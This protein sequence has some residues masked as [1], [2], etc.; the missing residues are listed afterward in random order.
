MARMAVGLT[1]MIDNTGRLGPRMRAALA[2]RSPGGIGHARRDPPSPPRKLS[3]LQPLHQVARLREAGGPLLPPRIAAVELIKILPPPWPSAAM[4]PLRPCTSTRNGRRRRSPGLLCPRSAPPLSL[5]SG[6]RRHL[7]PRHL[8]RWLVLVER[9]LAA[10]RSSWHLPRPPA[11]PN[12]DSFDPRHSQSW[13]NFGFDVVPQK[14]G[15]SHREHRC[16]GERLTVATI[17]TAAHRLAASMRCTIPPQ[18][19]SAS[20]SR[21]HALPKSRMILSDISRA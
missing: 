5:L 6:H 21:I 18:D 4:S 9:R 17:R 20:P 11:L 15:N 3:N 12:L 14:A 10:G 8:T 13:H 7:L 1:A 2:R 19:L 16:L